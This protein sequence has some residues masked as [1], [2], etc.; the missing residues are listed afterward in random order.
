MAGGG[1]ARVTPRDHTLGGASARGDW[2]AGAEER[3]GWRAAAPKIQR[4]RAVYARVTG[5]AIGKS[6]LHCA[7]RCLW[8]CAAAAPIQSQTLALGAESIH[9]M[10]GCA[11]KPVADAAP[12][13]APA[14]KDVAV[15][16]AKP[17]A[18]AATPP[19]AEPKDPLS[20]VGWAPQHL[21][22]C[23]A[24]FDDEAVRLAQLRSLAFGREREAR[25]DNITK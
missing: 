24:Q 17:E 25:F 6:A 14:P 15:A 3:R 16:P 20:P 23:G 18:A 21:A 8:S 11:S 9:E 19:A 4:K 1:R 10:G 12:P 5:I 13:P 2:V 22:P 7:G